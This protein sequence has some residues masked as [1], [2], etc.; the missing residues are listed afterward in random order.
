MRPARAVKLPPWPWRV[1]VKGRLHWQVKVWG[2]AK[3]PVQLKGKLV[4]LAGLPVSAPQAV[5]WG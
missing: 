3:V 5:W 1:P 2:Q 4:A